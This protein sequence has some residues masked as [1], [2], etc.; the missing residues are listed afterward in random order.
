MK[1]CSS[2]FKISDFYHFLVSLKIFCYF[3]I[4]FHVLP[5]LFLFFRTLIFENCFC[6]L[7]NF[8]FF[9]KICSPLSK[10]SIL[11]TFSDFFQNLCYFNIFHILSIFFLLFRT[12]SALLFFM[13]LN[14]IFN[15]CE[16]FLFSS[17]SFSFLGICS[18]PFKIFNFFQFICSLSY[19]SMVF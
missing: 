11:L 1:T 12:L 18:P 4:F 15:F 16:F 10:I 5:I 17:K 14:K 3:N 6:F 7:R 2:L 9:L 13:T 8:P 19:F